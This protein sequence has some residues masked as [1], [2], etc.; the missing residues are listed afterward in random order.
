MATHYDSYE[1]ADES[2]DAEK[3]MVC[4]VRLE[5]DA[6]AYFVMPREAEDDAVHDAGFAIR[7]GKPMDSYQREIMRL[8][9]KGSE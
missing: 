8:A 9:R 5:D 3:E 1:A 6:A 7:H 4:G 2:R